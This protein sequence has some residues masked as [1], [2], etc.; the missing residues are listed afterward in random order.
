M[1]DAALYVVWC[2]ARNRF[3]VRLRRLRE[4]R[5]LLGAAVWIGY[6]V[7]TLGVRQRIFQTRGASRPSSSAAAEAA[8]VASA[9]SVLGPALGGAALAC[10]AIGT[11]V[12]PF[13]SNL[14]A[15]SPAETALLVSAPLSRRQLVFYRL[16]RSQSAVLAGALIMA[17]AYPTGSLVGRLRGLVGVWLLL[18]TGHL[19][20]TIVTLGRAH[21]RKGNGLPRFAWPAVA[22][23]VAA[24]A[25]TLW[26]LIS[27]PGI[28]T[29][30]DGASLIDMLETV[31]TS[32][33]LRVFLFPFTALV[34]PF[35][36]TGTI[37]FVIALAAACAAYAVAV[38][39]LVW[40]DAC[41]P[42]VAD[43]S[44]D[45]QSVLPPRRDA[46]FRHRELAW[47]LAP[48][49]R[50]EVVFA[51]KAAL[52]T[53]RAVDGSMLV[54]LLTLLIAMATAILF[55]TRALGL[56]TLFGAL[57]TLGALF[58][59]LMAPQIVRMDLREDLAHLV[60]LKAW[61]VR[62]AAVLRGEILW[63]ATIVTAVA[64]VFGVMALVLSMVSSSR[65]PLASRSA[66]WLAFLLLIPGVVLAQYTIHNAIAVIFPGWI[67]LGASRPRGADA[68]GQRMIVLAA[69]WG[70]MLLALV[71]GVAVTVVLS[72]L[73]RSFVGA[74]ALSAGALVTTLGVVGEMLLVTRSL[75]PVY[76][77]L[78]VTSTE[79]P[80]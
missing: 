60:W 12:L 25:A 47:R 21:L 35:F 15:F 75:G 36:A 69:S 32:G 14:L 77:R 44:I 42:D 11:W 78:D 70:A 50:P 34:H 41:S 40:A 10:L 17:V 56:V 8:S 24:L 62:G 28:A 48:S 67:P 66:A 9:F 65:I 13:G 76:E 31:A 23:P 57:C 39:W 53:L 1:W 2:T 6:L 27:N 43:A 72:W 7:I 58:T 74:W 19:F 73:L 71:P 52:R 64:W 59:T 22:L 49:G 79:R 45:R 16:M 26:P 80:D 38:T 37:E 18:T 4:P 46:T 20:A 33:P 61:P 30:A 54:R 55:A 51:W 68:A 3:R 29:G 5:Y 63:P